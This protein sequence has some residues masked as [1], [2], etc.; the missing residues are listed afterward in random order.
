MTPDGEFREPAIA[1]MTNATWLDRALA[2]VG[3]AALLLTLAAGGFVLIA[4]A[5]LLLGLLLPIVIGA[6]L[7]AFVTLWWRMHR[8]HAKDMAA[9]QPASGS[10]PSHQGTPPDGRAQGA[11]RPLGFIIIR[12]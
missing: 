6:G 2:R 5:V 10:G 8:M 1:G 4:V 11:P 3:G 7:V 12:R 9:R